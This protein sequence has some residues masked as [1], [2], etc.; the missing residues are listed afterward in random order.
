MSFLFWS[1]IL[2]VGILILGY[3]RASLIVNTIA[4]AFYIAVITVSGED[5]MNSSLLGM[6]WLIFASIAV[7][8]NVPALRRKLISDRVLTLFSKVTPSMSRT[9]KEA[10]E[11]G[12]VW[13]DGDLFSGKPDW[14]KLLRIP[15]P[16]LSESEQDYINGPVE[17]L[18][19]MLDDW[20]ITH[21]D[22]DLPTEV[23]QFIKR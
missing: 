6:I 11:A 9:E 7:P 13:W 18:C 2:A 21:E 1:I 5:P 20:K 8:L 23:W 16:Q 10:L 4:V 12:T 22:Y 15:R 14:S 19:K 3:L 17:D